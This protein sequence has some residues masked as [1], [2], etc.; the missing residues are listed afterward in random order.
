MRLTKRKRE[1]IGLFGADAWLIFSEHLTPLFLEFHCLEVR[2]GLQF[3]LRFGPPLAASACAMVSLRISK[4]T[5]IALY[6]QCF[7]D[8]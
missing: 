2:E 7:Y 5:A 3:L 8:G 1:L 6:C 4:E